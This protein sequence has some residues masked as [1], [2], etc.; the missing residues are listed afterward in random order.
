MF[1]PFNSAVFR[2]TLIIAVPIIFEALVF[3]QSASVASV[4][5]NSSAIAAEKLVA[6]GRR[7]EQPATADS[8]RQAIEK[9]QQAI[10]LWQAAKDTAWEAKTLALIASAYINLGEKQNAF[11]FA[12]RAL[13][14]SENAVKE[15]AEEQRPTPG[16]LPVI[17][18]PFSL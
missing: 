9:Y 18:N 4:A 6:E 12:N 5:E 16:R 10:S 7:I 8:R 3:P 11:D 1:R 17:S 14:L 13:P 15:C 2:L